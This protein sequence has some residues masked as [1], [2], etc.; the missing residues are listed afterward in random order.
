MEMD[1]KMLSKLINTIQEDI[2]PPCGLK[3][4]MFREIILLSPIERFIFQKPLRTA[5]ALSIV[6]S[7]ILWAVMG[8]AYSNLI[9]SFLE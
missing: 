5:C 9:L 4:E 1:D 3:E 7:G 8:S 6:I 2:V